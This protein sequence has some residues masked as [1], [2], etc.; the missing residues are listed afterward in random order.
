MAHAI[1]AT[2]RLA[3]FSFQSENENVYT[4]SEGP[5]D[6]V[7]RKS[8]QKNN[9]RK[10]P[11]AGAQPEADTNLVDHRKYKT[12]LCRTWRETGVLL[13]PAFGGSG[14][15]ALCNPNLRL[16]PCPMC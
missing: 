13:A 3:P 15:L 11:V 1:L 8:H 10:K 14:N 16:E 4:L 12:K 6:K 2:L 9:R 5:D 7:N